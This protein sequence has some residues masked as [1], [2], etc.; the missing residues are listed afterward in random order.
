MLMSDTDSWEDRSTLLLRTCRSCGKTHTRSRIKACPSCQAGF[1]HDSY[2]KHRTKISKKRRESRSQRSQGEIVLANAK[3][4]IAVYVKRGK[5]AKGPCRSCPSVENLRPVFEDPS[6]PLEVQWICRPCAFEDSDMVIRRREE[7]QS[8]QRAAQ[9]RKN[10][11]SVEERLALLAPYDLI[12]LKAETAKSLAHLRFP[13]RD[14]SPLFHQS[15][16]KMYLSKY[17]IDQNL[18]TP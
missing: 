18:E 3:A 5:I 10:R 16:V 6:K 17:P 15:L 12:E 7:D 9:W 8:I 13:V 2:R 14:G 11:L 1:S 4:Y